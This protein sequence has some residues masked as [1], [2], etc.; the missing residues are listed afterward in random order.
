MDN[1]TDFNHTCDGLI[2]VCT[3]TQDAIEFDQ[4]LLDA[5]NIENTSKALTRPPAGRNR[6]SS[7]QKG[8]KRNRTPVWYTLDMDPTKERRPWLDLD[9]RTR[10]KLSE[11]QRTRAKQLKKSIAQ[12]SAPQGGPFASML[13][14]SQAGSSGGKTCCK[15]TLLHDWVACMLKHINACGSQAAI[16]PS[17]LLNRPLGGQLS[18]RLRWIHQQEQVQRT[19][20]LL[21]NRPTWGRLHHQVLHILMTQTLTTMMTTK[22]LA[23]AP[24]LKGSG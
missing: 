8:V 2:D 18:D 10:N 17:W 23:T 19:Y 24:Q 3:Q 21:R 16:L 9:K 1:N 20:R 15:Y 5:Q 11:N 13:Q 6:A 12:H 14:Q 7:N 4:M 22:K